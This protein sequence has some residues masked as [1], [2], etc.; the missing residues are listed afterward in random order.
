MIVLSSLSFLF[1]LIIVTHTRIILPVYYL[2]SCAD[3]DCEQLGFKKKMLVLKC[4]T[5]GLEI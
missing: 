5:L 2:T 1:Y 4:F 3:E